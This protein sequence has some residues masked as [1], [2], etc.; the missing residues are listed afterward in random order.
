MSK[1]YTHLL[2]HIFLKILPKS[3]DDRFKAMEDEALFKIY[4]FTKV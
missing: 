1:T 2:N 4:F 3:D